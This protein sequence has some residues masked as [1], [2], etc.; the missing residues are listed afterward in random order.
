[1]PELL[2]AG[3]I[4]IADERMRLASDVHDGVIQSLAGAALRLETARQLLHGD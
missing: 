4:A 3:L 1:M 2:L